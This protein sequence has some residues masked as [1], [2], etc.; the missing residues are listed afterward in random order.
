MG[1]FGVLE[2]CLPEGEH[3]L[4]IARHCSFAMPKSL[5]LTDGT[6]QQKEPEQAQR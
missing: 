3:A 2:L 1:C 6:D 5:G 4:R